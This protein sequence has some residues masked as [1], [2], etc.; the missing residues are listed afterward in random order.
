MQTVTDFVNNNLSFLD[1]P[2]TVIIIA[3]A[4]IA[5]AFICKN[6][7]SKLVLKY[8][9]LLSKKFPT[10][11]DDAGTPVLKKPLEWLIILGGIWLAHAIL[12]E[13]LRGPLRESISKGVGLGFVAILALI[14]H[15]SAKLL[16][17]Y[18]RQHR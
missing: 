13:Y 11:V 2:G 4:V 5:L 16:S 12:S 1:I 6:L 8:V 3:A 18:V 15:R 9:Q 10:V 17:N 7:F 14:T